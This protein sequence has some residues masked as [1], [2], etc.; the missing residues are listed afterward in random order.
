MIGKEYENL[1]LPDKL[2][3]DKTDSLPRVKYEPFNM[4]KTLAKDLF[5]SFF[6]DKHFNKDYITTLV[7][8]Y[9]PSEEYRNIDARHR[10]VFAQGGYVICTFDE[11]K[12]LGI[13]NHKKVNIIHLD[14]GEQPTGSYMFSDGEMNVKDAVEKADKFLDEKVLNHLDDLKVKAKSVIIYEN[15]DDPELGH[16]Y[17]IIY[18]KY[19]NGAPISD[20]PGLRDLD[21]HFND[22]VEVF[23]NSS[24]DILG[25]RNLMYYQE[26]IDATTDETNEYITLDSALKLTQKELAGYRIVDISNIKINYISDISIKTYRPFWTFEIDRNRV[27]DFDFIPRDFIL[28]DMHTGEVIV[29]FKE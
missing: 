19:L 29:S 18:S 14:R 28:V 3:I 4:D 15:K 12:S 24:K 7:P 13:R 21:K 23:I 10:G 1:K 2:H 22:C 8:P 16:Y 6:G 27:D 20:I 9:T 25:Y 5:S 17:V 26:D 11:D